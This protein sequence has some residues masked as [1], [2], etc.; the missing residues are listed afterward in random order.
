MTKVR[1]V[2]KVSINRAPVLTLWAVVVAERLGFSHDVALTLGKAI[3]GLTAF[4]KGKATGVF[5]V[6]LAAS[7]D[8]KES[9]RCRT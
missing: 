8:P 7:R 2:E 6:A 4:S 3:A 9:R 5:Q 1:L